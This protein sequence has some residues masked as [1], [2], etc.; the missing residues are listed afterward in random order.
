MR[1]RGTGDQELCPTCADH[2][3]PSLPER[4]LA[5]MQQLGREPDVA[6]IVRKAHL[7][8]ERREGGIFLTAAAIDAFN[9]LLKARKIVPGSR[10]GYRL[11]GR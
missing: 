9:G 8:T 1:Q 7:P 5:A 2:L 10:G 6:R 11:A 4:I 3:E